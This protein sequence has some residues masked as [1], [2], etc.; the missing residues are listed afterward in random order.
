MLSKVYVVNTPWIFNA[1][2]WGLK[3]ILPA[4]SSSSFYVYVPPLPHLLTEPKPRS[5]SNPLVTKKIFTKRSIP[6][7]S[8][9]ILEGPMREIL[10]SHSNLILLREAFFTALPM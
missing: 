3:V 6:P 8:Q 5:G 9:T 10:I 1:F 7:T 2:W 4:R